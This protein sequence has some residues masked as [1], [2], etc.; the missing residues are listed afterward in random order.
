MRHC[1]LR[2]SIMRIHADSELLSVRILALH[3]H[4]QSRAVPAGAERPLNRGQKG[5]L[6]SRIRWCALAR[7]FGL[8]AA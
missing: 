7:I 1:E 2:I 4:Q 6:V 5:W 3:E 8:P